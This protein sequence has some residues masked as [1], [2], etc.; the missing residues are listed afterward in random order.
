MR[1]TRYAGSGR[2]CT[3][4]NLSSCP[5]RGPPSQAQPGARVGRKLG[6]LVTCGA[7]RGRSP[8]GRR[9][10]AVMMRGRGWRPEPPIRELPDRREP[11]GARGQPGG[12]G[13]RDG[14]QITSDSIF[15]AAG[16]SF[17]IGWLLYWRLRSCCF[18]AAAPRGCC[19]GPVYIAISRAA[20]RSLD[21]SM[22]G[23]CGVAKGA[24]PGVAPA[25]PGPDR[26]GPGTALDIARRLAYNLAGG[27]ARHRYC[28]FAFYMPRITPDLALLPL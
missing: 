13:Y 28:V 24:G 20:Y 9:A 23:M 17:L 12:D 10:G 7:A 19:L 2:L 22:A 18:T 5:R 21:R 1:K 3:G 26:G 16:D 11:A 27:S 6:K 25:K 8:G 4:S 15:V 14:A